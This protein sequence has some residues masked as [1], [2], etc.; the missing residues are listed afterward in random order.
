MR[1]QMYNLFGKEYTGHT[2]TSMMSM[3]IE[4]AS[5]VAVLDLI[6]VISYARGSNVQNLILPMFGVGQVRAL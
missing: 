5:L 4:S 1:R 3:L 2:Y 6:F